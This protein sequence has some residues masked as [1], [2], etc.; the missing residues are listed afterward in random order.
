[1]RGGV[2]ISGEAVVFHLVMHL[3]FVGRQIVKKASIYGF[4]NN[5]L[6]DFLQ[7]YVAIPR[8]VPTCKR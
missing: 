1:M 5:Q 7:I 2:C 6:A 8:L 4:K 3:F